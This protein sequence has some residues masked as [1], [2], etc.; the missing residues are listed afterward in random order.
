M[1]DPQV[2]DK[3]AQDARLQQLEARTYH[4]D[5]EVAGLKT[6]VGGV[7][8]S[9]TRIENTLLNKPEKWN[10]GSIIALL[11]LFVTIV[12]GGA[13]FL[14]SQMAH[15]R[16]DIVELSEEATVN[17]EFRN[18]MHYEVGVVQHTIKVND[19]K[20]NHFDE[21]MHKRDDRI[22]GIENKQLGMGEKLDSMEGLQ[23]SFTERALKAIE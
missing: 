7:V 9:L 4:I 15:V 13:V 19:D 17:R 3:R 6:Q 16:D 22:N 12:V 20:W 21:M 2:V 18:Q 8:D 1:T 5:G 11:S 10:T 23:Q 14:E